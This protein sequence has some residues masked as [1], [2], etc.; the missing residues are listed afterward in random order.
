M[1]GPEVDAHIKRN[2]DL[3]ETLN[4]RGTPA[5]IV[6]NEMTPGAVDLPMFK[7][8]VADARKAE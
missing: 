6:G 1:N 4:I 3:A 5:F 2:Y 7:K 8:L